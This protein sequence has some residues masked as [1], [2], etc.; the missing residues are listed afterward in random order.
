MTVGLFSADGFSNGHRGGLVR[1]QRARGADTA[2][3]PDLPVRSRRHE[4]GIELKPKP[5]NPLLGQALNAHLVSVHP[6][7]KGGGAPR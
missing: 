7:F 6:G 5:S 3:R 4:E 1:A 2:E